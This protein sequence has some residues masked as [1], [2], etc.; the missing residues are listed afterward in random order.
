MA[1]ST[2]VRTL[3][4]SGGDYTT[5]TAWLDDMKILYP[6]L[7]AL[8]I[9]L[10]LDMYNDWPAGLDEL[11]WVPFSGKFTSGPD[12]RFIL[13]VP[14]GEGHNGT[15]GTGFWIN[16][17]SDE[18][19]FHFGYHYITID[20]IEL[21]APIAS[22]QLLGASSNAILKNSILHNIVSQ[23]FSTD[24]GFYAENCIT[25]NTALTASSIYG[26]SFRNSKLKNITS[27][28]KG[29][30]G[31]WNSDIV[32]Y[33]C[34]CEDVYV[35]HDHEKIKYDLF[36]NC[37]GSYVA[38]LAKSSDGLGPNDY[39]LTD[40]SD[41]VD[42]DNFD[43][44][45][46]STSPLL[47]AGINGGTLGA[48]FVET[49]GGGQTSTLTGVIINPFTGEISSIKSSLSD[50]TGVMVNS[51]HTQSTSTK[52]TGSL[53]SGVI[54]HPLTSDS[55]SAKETSS[56]ISGAV[57]PPIAGVASSS[58]ESESK[59]SAIYG[60]SVNSIVASAISHKE[61][62]SAITGIKL[63]SIVSNAASSKS[64]S[65][66][67]TG[68]KSTPKLSVSKSNKTTLSTLSGII[69][70][71][72]VG[73]VSSIKSTFSFLSGLIIN[74]IIARFKGEIKSLPDYDPDELST[75]SATTKR[76]VNSKSNVYSVKSETT[77]Y[78]TI[79]EE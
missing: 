54:N 25:Y 19:V 12:N 53:L 8:D 17:S 36:Y 76:S 26:L 9:N 50:I 43:F 2:I 42:P 1:S 60:V 79:S 49:G 23:A 15:A 28:V 32:F 21:S 57:I 52:I 63:N 6:D 27:H 75:I 41:L 3:K 18:W 66:T 62:S 40:D 24:A 37:T 20:G 13:N 77:K 30:S 22:K 71:G 45:F 64:T 5:I 39:I 33:S 67:I 11:T 56:L 44:R 16:S 59:I 14:T 34:E 58:K 74:P 38:Y 48:N 55:A 4:A 78:K 31:G 65:S 69:V 61:S 51:L 10:Q 47:T 29:T 70:S 73:V 72:S 46:K 35:Y 7:I 68:V